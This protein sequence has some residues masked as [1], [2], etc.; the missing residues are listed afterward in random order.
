[1]RLQQY[2]NEGNNLKFQLEKEM[3]RLKI[4]GY[5]KDSE[6]SNIKII[7]Y[8]VMF[9]KGERFFTAQLKSDKN[10]IKK[11]SIEIQTGGNDDWT[12]GTYGGTR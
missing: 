9:Q 8:T 1:M 2:I 7:G 4:E 10:K 3:K 5:P 11:K 12:R 6:I